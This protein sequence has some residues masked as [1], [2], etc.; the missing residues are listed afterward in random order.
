MKKETRKEKR[1]DEK[2]GETIS[3]KRENRERNEKYFYIS[4]FFISPIDSPQL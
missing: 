3:K 1:E 4:L 2:K